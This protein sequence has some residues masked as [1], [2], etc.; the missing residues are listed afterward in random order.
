MSGIQILQTVG[1]IMKKYDKPLIVIGIDPGQKGG[2]AYIDLSD[3][4]N[5]FV[6][7]MP[8]TF[9]ETVNLFKEL[10]EKFC[11]IKVFIES[12]HAF[13]ERGVVSTFNFGVHYG[14]LLGMCYALDVD[15]EE[16]SYRKWKNKVIG[17]SVK[18]ANRREGKNFAIEFAKSKFSHLEKEIGKSDGKAE[19]LLIALYGYT[20]IL[21][22]DNGTRTE[23][24]SSKKNKKSGKTSTGKSSS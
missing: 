4:S 24:R 20:M 6:Y 13:P 9:K 18:F 12:Q 17:K 11:V 21:E 2:I 10:M 5:S 15:V 7:S 16:V 3:L 22:V 8:K 19:A 14:M 1:E 23:K